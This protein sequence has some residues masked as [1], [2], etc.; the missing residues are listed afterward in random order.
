[1]LSYL[2]WKHSI[3]YRFYKM[4]T[5][6]GQK[7]HQLPEFILTIT[8]F[9]Y[10]ITY[11]W[12]QHMFLWCVINISILSL[13]H[14]PLGDLNEILAKQF[15]K[16]I[17]VI[18]GWSI[19]CEIALRWMPLGLTDDKSTLVQVMAWCR[20]GTSHYLSQCWPRSMSP[21]GVTRP[22]WANYWS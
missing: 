7:P 15:F 19:F 10:V 18:G 12:L 4:H 22:Q 17:S 6:S 21:Y 20:Q 5:F 14:W 9:R 16:I 1:M 8:D 13:T 3:I 2:L 11:I